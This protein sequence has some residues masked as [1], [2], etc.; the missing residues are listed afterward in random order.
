MN[1]DLKKTDDKE[2][3][4]DRTLQIK[5]DNIHYIILYT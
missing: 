3:H 2:K 5:P 4:S 1:N